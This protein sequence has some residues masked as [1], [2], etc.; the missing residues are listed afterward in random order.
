M[1]ISIKLMEYK[2]GKNKYEKKNIGSNGLKI[3]NV[4]LIFFFL[5]TRLVLKAKFKLDQRYINI[6]II[7]DF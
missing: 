3:E 4:N 2:E 7:C 6:C 5:K 1:D